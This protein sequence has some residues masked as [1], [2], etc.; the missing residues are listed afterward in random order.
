MMFFPP[1]LSATPWDTQHLEILFRLGHFPPV[2]SILIPYSARTKTWGKN[3]SRVCG[4]E[5]VFTL[6]IR[7]GK[8]WAELSFWSSRRLGLRMTSGALRSC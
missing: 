7:D 1:T 4:R 5:L 3:G 2:G 6:K 8:Y